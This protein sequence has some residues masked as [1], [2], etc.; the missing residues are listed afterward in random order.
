LLWFHVESPYAAWTR[1]Y[2]ENG[3]TWGSVCRSRLWRKRG[4]W[5]I[6]G[7][8]HNGNAVPHSTVAMGRRKLYLH[9]PISVQPGVINSSRNWSIMTSFW[10]HS[11]PILVPAI[12]GGARDALS[13]SLQIA[14]VELEMNTPQASLW[15]A[16]RLIEIG[17]FVA[18][19]TTAVIAGRT[20]GCGL[21]VR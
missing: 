18:D 4:K 7:E 10:R 2:S 14:R 13:A 21:S 9:S 5:A 11:A 17:P 8:P 15:V 19:L 16:M 20:G 3:I 6:N 12:D 1:I